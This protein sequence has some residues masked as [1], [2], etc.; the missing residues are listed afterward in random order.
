MKSIK[1]AV[2]TLILISVT[3]FYAQESTINNHE[4]TSYNHALELYQNK[5]YVAAQHKFNNLK[6]SFDNSSELNANCEYYAANCAVR[7]GQPDS[8]ELMQN[9]VDKYPTSTKINSA[10]NQIR[11]LRM[12]KP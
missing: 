4:L 8:D 9:F 6:Q 10:S 7:L 3:C 2:K 11:N 5:A 1:I 12:R